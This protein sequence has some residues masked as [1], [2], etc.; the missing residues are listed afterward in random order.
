VE[1]ALALLVAVGDV[2]PVL[3]GADLLVLVVLLV[4]VVVG[5]RLE[6][7]ELYLP[8]VGADVLPV[9]LVVDLLVLVLLQVVGQKKVVDLDLGSVLELL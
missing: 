8:V 5:L 2:L 3:R 1:V 7:V 9:L 4:G 6:G